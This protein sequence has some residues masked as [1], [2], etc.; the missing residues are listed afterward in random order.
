MKYAFTVV[1]PLGVVAE[2]R[3]DAIDKAKDFLSTVFEAEGVNG[4]TYMVMKEPWIPNAIFI[5]ENGEEIGPYT[6]KE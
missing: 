4:F 1:V 2:K 5:D 3:E 6:Q